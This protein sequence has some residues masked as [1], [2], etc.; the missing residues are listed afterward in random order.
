M[1]TVT[2]QRNGE[3]I[4]VKLVGLIDENSNLPELNAS[5]GRISID[6]ED[7]KSINSM[8]C[9]QW[10]NWLKNLPLSAGKVSLQKCSP[11]IVQ[12][13]SILLGFLPSGVNVESFYVPYFCPE[14]GHEDLDLLEYG[15]D[16]SAGR[17]IKDLNDLPCPTCSG[18]LQL[19]V[20][21]NKYFVFIN[22]KAS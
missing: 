16:F 13:F 18:S 4:H 21:A 9:S 2:I 8:G 17:L 19:D 7:I 11:A 14:C 10:I 15:K 22:A 12:Q 1:L 6:L 3:D 20:V 5:N